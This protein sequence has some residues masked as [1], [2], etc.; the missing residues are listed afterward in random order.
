MLQDLRYAFRT[1]IKNPGF[2]FVAVVALAL[3]IGA[4]SAI[5]S[6]VYAVLLRPLP[7]RDPANLVMVFHSYPQLS[8]ASVSPPNYTDYLTMTRSFESMGAEAMWSANLTGIGE[9]ERLTGRRVTASY[10][11]A[12]GVAPTLGRTFLEQ[13]DHPGQNKVVVLGNGFWKRRLGGDPGILNQTVN[14]NGASYTVVGIMPAGFRTDRE[15]DV[16]VPMAFTPEELDT[17]ERGSEFL[18]MYAR[19]R[20]GMTVEAARKD[21]TSVADRLRAA[22]YR[23]GSQWGVSVVPLREQLVGDLRG[24]LLILFAAV[25]VV[26]LIACANVASLLLARAA[27]RRREIAIRRA[28]GATQWRLMRLLLTECVLLAV[29]GGAAGLLAALWGSSLLTSALPVE[30][31]R[32]IPGWDQIA[33]NLPVLGFTFAVA[34]FTGLLFGI[35]PALQTSRQGLSASLK[36]GSRGSEGM[37]R[38][39]A[40]HALVVSEFALSLVLLIGASLLIHSFWR[41]QQVN[42]GFQPNGLLTFSISVPANGY[43]NRAAIG[44]FYNR[45]LDEIR[46]IPGVQAAGAVSNLPLSGDNQNAS[47]FVEGL[48]LPANGEAPHGDPRATGAGYFEAMRIP[49]IRGRTFTTSDAA[50]SQFVAVIDEKLAEKYFPG[51]DPVGH[52]IDFASNKPRWR[53]IVGV[54]GHVKHYGLDGKDLRS[55]KVQ[56]YFPITQMTERDMYLVVRG[57]GEPAELGLAIRAAVA[58]LDPTMPIYAVRTM[59]RVREASLAQRRLLMT[60]LAFFAAVALTL[61]AIGIYGVMSYGVSQR[62][63]EIGIRMAL[64]ARPGD[65]LRMV[66]GQGLALAAIGAAIGICGGWAVARLMNKLLFGISAADPLTFLGVPLLLGLVALTTTWFAARRA[67]RVDPLVALRDE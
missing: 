7:V 32:D 46:S 54:V 39:R 36:E 31:S 26:L 33:V 34:V 48:P 19:L 57:A 16:M 51:Q 15:T 50:D 65:V 43:P 64:G 53:Q 18:Y 47:F 25:G 13:E 66:A 38:S 11:T 12:L 23:P 58:R 17:R 42:P 20:P 30:L 59:E 67:T 61:A 2:A 41:V 62:I 60:L 10:F 3:G 5:F 49:L 4:N 1:V 28:I 27:V 37:A 55:D 14:L 22:F 8:Q 35:M 52:R 44:G 40:R 56:Y 45:L 21:M 24:S 6:V 29:M 9:P 63:K